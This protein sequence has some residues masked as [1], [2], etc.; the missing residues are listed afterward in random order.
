MRIVYASMIAV[1]GLSAVLAQA[2]MPVQASPASSSKT[3]EAASSQPAA[4]TPA[5]LR[6]RLA[7]RQLEASAHN[8][9]ATERS[10]HRLPAKGS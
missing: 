2:Q 6:I 7:K 9:N 8:S 10:R 3:T 1:W 4:E 5:Q